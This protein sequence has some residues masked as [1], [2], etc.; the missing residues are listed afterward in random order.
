MHVIS[1]NNFNNWYELLWG[2][3]LKL[4]IPH[5]VSGSVVLKL[6]KVYFILY[7]TLA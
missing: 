7:L 2:N 4:A 1:Y 3:K 6:V 5:K